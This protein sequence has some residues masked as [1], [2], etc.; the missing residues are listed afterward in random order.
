MTLFA[1]EVNAMT[2][3]AAKLAD[4][5][6]Q[7][8]H[9]ILG[10]A[11]RVHV[12]PSA[13]QLEVFIKLLF[14]PPAPPTG[15]GAQVAAFVPTQ[16]Q[17]P[18]LV[19]LVGPLSTPASMA[20]AGWWPD[21]NS[22]FELT[23]PPLLFRNFSRKLIAFQLII[24]VMDSK[25]IDQGTHSLCGPVVLMEAFA[26]NHPAAYVAYVCGLA[27][28]GT[29]AVQFTGGAKTITLPTDSNIFGKQS[30]HT[31][32]PEADYIALASL[33]DQGFWL[34]HTPYRSH[35]TNQMI[36]GATTASTLVG[37]MRDAGYTNIENRTVTR[38]LNAVTNL[39]VGQHARDS[40]G[41]SLMRNSVATAAQRIAQGHSVF[42]AVA[43]NLATYALGRT[44]HR[45]A[46]LVTAFAGHWVTLLS[47]NIVA[48]VPPGPG[49]VATRGGVQFEIRT[50]TKDSDTTNL[51]TVPWSKVG[52]WY[53]GFVCGTP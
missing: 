6:A 7:R 40:V 48:T 33:R 19:A 36:Q 44:D 51:E 27:L 15:G 37:W 2:T 52:N 28:N 34:F 10:C 45:D 13:A 4:T 42:M 39:A 11:R 5:P 25:F 23:G 22:F 1:A 17:L 29:G 24:R 18:A 20:H 35:F 43:G 38:V 49:V 47:V 41:E 16:L 50:W 3:A 9:A 53:R 14:I 8:R 32:I 46:K 26:R 30:I 12:A 21:P 31:E